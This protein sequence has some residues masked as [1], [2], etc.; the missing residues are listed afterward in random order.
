MHREGAGLEPTF[1]A[2]GVPPIG[3]GSGA[4]LRV[5]LR[6]RR[7][8]ITKVGVFG[9]MERSSGET[10]KRFLRAAPNNYHCPVSADWLLVFSRILT[11]RVGS[12]FAQLNSSTC[13]VIVRNGLLSTTT[14][15]N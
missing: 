2:L 5:H 12:S 13:F 6:R 14:N 4:G 10:R 3:G 8:G 9:P 1:G 7:A 11:G 15:S